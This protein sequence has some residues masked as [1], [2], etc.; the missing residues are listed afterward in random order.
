MEKWKSEIKAVH[1]SD[2]ELRAV[3]KICVFLCEAR[4]ELVEENMYRDG[5]YESEE[6]IPRFSVRASTEKED[7]STSYGLEYRRCLSRC[8]SCRTRS[9]DSSS[10]A[11]FV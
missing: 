8:T 6:V 7:V 11:I 5:V 1:S 4:A 9:F 10:C 2:Y 3:H